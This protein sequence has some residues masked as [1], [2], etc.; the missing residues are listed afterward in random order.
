M[1]EVLLPQHDLT[2]EQSG[3]AA[4]DWDQQTLLTA[5]AGTGKTTTLVARIADLVARQDIAPSELIVLTFT[6]AAVQVVRDR[7]KDE[8]SPVLANV[9][10]RTFDSFATR[11][12]SHTDPEGSWTDVAYDARIEAA[13][14]CLRDREEAQEYAGTFRHL[15]VDELQDLV[16]PRDTFV[17]ELLS[18]ISGGWTLAGDPAQGIY[19][20]QM[21][22]ST[23][24]AGVEFFDKVRRQFGDGLAEEVLT[25]NFRARSDVTREMLKFGPELVAPDADFS[26]LHDQMSAAIGTLPSLNGLDEAV[27]ML[28][29]GLE[30]RTAILCRSNWQALLVS[31]QLWELGVEHLLH[32]GARERPVASWVAL[33]SEGAE[34][35]TLKAA[36]AEERYAAMH[37]ADPD[38]TAEEAVKA[39]R[40]VA[41]SPKGALDLGEASRRISAGDVPPEL[42]P[43]PRSRLTV[44][45]IH[46][47][48]GLE[49]NNVLLTDPY[50]RKDADEGE[51]AEEARVL[52]VALTRAR[53]EIW[54][55]DAPPWKWGI[56]YVKESD[57]RW[58]RRKN[59]GLVALEL[60]GDDLDATQPAGSGIS[61][62]PVKLQGEIRHLKRGTPVTCELIPDRPGVQGPVYRVKC[63]EIPI[64]VTSSWFATSLRR[65]G[66]DFPIAFYGAR[67]D[68]VDTG[69]GPPAATKDAGLGASGLWLK[70]RVVGLANAV[71]PAK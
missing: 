34:F 70:P 41:R 4:A 20:F 62:D 63:G 66:R 36:R 67:I 58:A 68:G 47:A 51:I 21:A 61:L 38:L 16:Q 25:R 48:K 37:E 23:I 27:P 8:G 44:S 59:G 10:V 29:R 45:T 11:I 69:A 56:R 13:T 14:Q 22:G 28:E 46:R 15:I 7:L 53:D 60:R 50:L 31:R 32:K 43:V 2:E 9:R 52:Y 39:F 71:W 30:G 49:F 42:T 64:G 26:R 17:A 1:P 65:I 57:G 19:G 24:N 18:L 3:V 33:V 5:G 35:P 55:F 54:H 12:L 40:R 6:R